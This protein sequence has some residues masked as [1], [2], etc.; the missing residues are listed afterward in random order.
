[1]LGR[2]SH[3]VEPAT[4]S[5][6]LAAQS[7][8]VWLPCLMY[9]IGGSEELMVNAAHAKGRGKEEASKGW[10]GGGEQERRRGGLL[11]PSLI[12]VQGT[13]ET[14]HHERRC[15]L[16]HAS[17]QTPSQTFKL[18]HLHSLPS[19]PHHHRHTEG[20]ESRTPQQGGQPTANSSSPPPC[21]LPPPPTTRTSLRPR[22]RVVRP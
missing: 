16:I 15:P 14:H 9:G 7:L 1:M 20:K 4:S 21:P 6:C 13:H 5:A 12:C 17:V 2:I 22:P 3:A 8:D 18:S 10:G 11:L 19:P